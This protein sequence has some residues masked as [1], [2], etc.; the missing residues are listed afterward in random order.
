MDKQNEKG[1]PTFQMRSFPKG[2][3]QKWFL[4]CGACN[5]VSIAENAPIEG[6]AGLEN[7]DMEDERHFITVRE[8]QKNEKS[9][10]GHVEESD[11]RR[12]QVKGRDK[13]RKVD[14]DGQTI[15]RY[16]GFKKICWSG[17]NDDDDSDEV[18]DQ[19]G[20]GSFPEQ[21][22]SEPPQNEFEQK[23]FSCRETPLQQH[24]EDDKDGRMQQYNTSPKS[25]ASLVRKRVAWSMEPPQSQVQLPVENDASSVTPQR[26]DFMRSGKQSSNTPE[27]KT[28]DAVGK[29]VWVEKEPSR[30]PSTSANRWKRLVALKF[31]LNRIQTKRMERD[32]ATVHEEYEMM[33]ENLKLYGVL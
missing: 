29:P 19:S 22:W 11:P 9:T 21:N 13:N 23:T 30:A 2:R 4:I 25:R 12:S 5:V 7:T 6:N 1:K 33:M 24:K 26:E 31:K 17:S 16:E 32:D 18:D 15:E 27:S 14:G 28:N 8:A 10:S 20:V 3:R